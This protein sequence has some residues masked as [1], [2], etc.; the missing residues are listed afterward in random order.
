MS[1]PKRADVNAQLNIARDSQRQCA[2]LISQ[3]ENSAI[4]SLLRDAKRLRQ[5]AIVS[6]TEARRIAAGLSA[7]MARVAP[8]TVRDARRLVEEA[9]RAVAE[10]GAVLDRSRKQVE[11]TQRDQKAADAAFALANEEYERAEQALRDAGDAWYLCEEMEQAKE[12]TRLFDVAAEELAKADGSRKEAARTADEAIR[13]ANAALS[14]AMNA[15]NRVRATHSE[16]EARLRAEEEARRITEEKKRRATVAVQ[17]ARAALGRVENMPHGKFRPG[18]LEGHGRELDKAERL[19]NQEYYDE[20]ANAAQTVEK[21]ASQLEREIGEAHRE[22]ERRRMEAE[23]RIITLRAALDGMDDGLIREWAEDPDALMKG[24][25]ALEGAQSNVTAER[26]EDAGSL[27]QRALD[28]L[29]A[30][31]RSAAE[32]RSAHVKREKIGEAVMDALSELGFDVSFKPGSRTEALEIAGQTPDETGR[33]DFDIAIPLSGEVDFH[34][35]TP[36]GDTTCIAAIQELQ[37]RLAE[38][39]VQWNTTHW[40]HAEGAVPASSSSRVTEKEQQKVK[41]KN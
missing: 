39:G 21:R 19:L 20:A 33:G 8:D 12:A 6:T 41:R 9:D 10:A 5:Q 1:G 11:R 35:N 31:L 27:A 34:V 14:L 24:R 25:T 13:R 4:E 26:F 38:R 22:Y 15:L 16:A 7:E 17:Q 18:E 30:A 36:E 2:G 23:T 28:A 40:G 29:N 37:K 32:N 3:A